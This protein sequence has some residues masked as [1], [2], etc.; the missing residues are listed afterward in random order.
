MDGITMFVRPTSLLE[1]QHR[2]N[3]ITEIECTAY[4]LA[5][6]LAPS[7]AEAAVRAFVAASILRTSTPETSLRV[8]AHAA[9]YV[10]LV[11]QYFSDDGED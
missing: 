10:G 4:G 8:A 5:L 11:R 2:L 7:T 6:V 9:P 3:K 1:G